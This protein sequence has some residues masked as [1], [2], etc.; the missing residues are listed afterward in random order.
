MQKWRGR[1]AEY[2][3]KHREILEQYWLDSIEVDQ[4]REDVWLFN[5]I[6]ESYLFK[7]TETRRNKSE[8]IPSRVHT[9]L[10]MIILKACEAE[11][12]LP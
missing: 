1:F 12:P 5:S 10:H 7:I 9:E 4:P 8:S 3:K 11:K 6:M 2:V